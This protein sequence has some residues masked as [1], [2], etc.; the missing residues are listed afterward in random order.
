MSDIPA[1]LGQ[2]V[3]DTTTTVITNST[4]ICAAV[5]GNRVVSSP[6]DVANTR[7]RRTFE[8]VALPLRK[9]PLII[10]NKRW[11]FRLV[12]KRDMGFK[13]S[14]ALMEDYALNALASHMV[15]CFTPDTV[16]GWN[17]PFRSKDGDPLRIYAY[18]DSYLEF[19]EY[20]MK[21][22][23]EERAFYEIVFGEL[24]QKPHFDI[25]IAY[26]EFTQLCPGENIEATA[27]FIKDTVIAGCQQVLAER[28]IALD[29]SRDVLLYSSHGP[30]KQSY[31]IIL[32]NYCHDGNKEAK[33]FY[34]EVVKRVSTFTGGKYLKFIDPGVYSPRQQFRLV[35][36]QKQNSGRPKIFYE[37]YSYNQTEYT[38]TYSDDVTDM[39]MKKLTI[40][41]ESM[42]GFVAGC[43]FLPSW[44]PPKPFSDQQLQNMPDVDDAM[45]SQC[46]AM[47]KSKIPD[48][49]FT[50]R[51]VHGHM[52][53]LQRHS[54][55]WCPICVDQTEPHETENPYILVIG[56]KVYWDCRR[57]SNESKRLFLGYLAAT[58]EELMNGTGIAGVFSDP[59]EEDDIGEDEGVVMFGGFNLGAPT[60]APASSQVTHASPSPPSPPSTPL[61]TPTASTQPESTPKALPPPAIVIP[62]PETLTQNIPALLTNMAKKRAEAKYVRQTAEDVTGVRSF[63]SV[64]D[65]MPWKA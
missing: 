44:I 53:I 38:H 18:F 51:E 9:G 30:Q 46:L 48:S 62:P 17:G 6:D 29:M 3:P 64:S 31:H 40:V 27:A 50:L 54:P 4:I 16:Q 43:R 24:P 55:S 41:Y 13:R 26:A 7:A 23:P 35:G 61:T 57:R 36:C 49:P 22:R 45:V 10:Y 58:L 33:A 37:R 39:A 34:D 8:P 65:Q 21:F 63:R 2:F 20:M 56:G 52:I 32:N 59:V 60:L 11:Y 42:L 5:G 25:D 1:I 15:V 28:L 12:P 47:M 14:R 19:F